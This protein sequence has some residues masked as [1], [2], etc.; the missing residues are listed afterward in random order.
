MPN[1]LTIC[2]LGNPILGEI[3]KEVEDVSAP[4]IQALIDNLLYTCEK[5]GV[6]I[7]APQVERSL[8][9]CIISSKPSPAYPTAPIIEMM[10]IIN[11]VIVSTSPEKESGWEACLSFPGWRG[12]VPRYKSVTVS[13]TNRTGKAEEQTFHNFIARVLQHELDHLDGIMYQSRAD[14]KHLVSENVYLKLL[15]DPIWF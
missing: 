4:D 7:A 9:L 14:P 5:S 11:P 1:L 10:T 13:F 15:K 8:R 12:L 6:G 2:K 3:A